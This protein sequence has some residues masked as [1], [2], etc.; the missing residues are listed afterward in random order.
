MRRLTLLIVLLVGSA[1]A[2]A[3]GAG[4]EGAEPNRKGLDFFE[5]KIRPMLVTHC[6][7]CH[8]AGAVGKKNLKGGLLLDSRDASRTGGES[9]SAVV[10]GKPD[11]SLLISALKQ[12]SFKMPPKGKL[13]DELIAHFV[14]WIEMGAPDP[15]DGVT[16]AASSEIDLE[17]GRKHWA[18]QPLA[19]PP[20]P[21]VKD[22]GWARTP[23]DQFVRARQEAAEVTPNA[24]ADA[25]TLIR[26]AYFD[27]IGL[28]PQPED[29]ES[30]VSEVEKDP[31][32]AYGRLIDE[33]LNSE[34]YGERWARHWLDVT[35]FAESNGYAFDGD[36]PN[37]WHYRDFVIRALNSDMPYDQFVRLQIAGDLLTNLDVQ[38][39]D[40]AQAAVNTIAATGLL[41]AGTYTTQQTQ[42]ER[43]RSRYEQLDDIVST[44]GTS[45]LGLTV[46]CSRCHS[47]KF[48]PLSQFDYYRMA[49][50]FAEVGF[51]DTGINMQPEAF[52][53]AKNAYDAA[54]APLAAAR[55]KFEQEQFSGRFDQWI[56]SRTEESATSPASAKLEA[57]HHVGP[58]A[59]GNFDAAF[60]QVFPPEL[61]TELSQS[62]EDGKLKWTEQ[63]EWKDGEAHNDK[64]TGTNGA[65]YLF[66]VV[67]G[68]QP[69]VMSLSLG[70]DDGIKLWVNGREVLSKKVGRDVAA[71]D[72][73]TVVIQLAAGRNELLMK[74]VN[75]GGAT[76]F[77]F[78]A[79]AAATPADVT[80]ILA[81]PV[82]KRD[83]PQKQKLVDWYKGYDLDWL[84]LNQLVARQETQNP[85][86]DLT[87]V[88]AARVRGTTY[89]F[90]DDTFK[91]YHLRR[92]NAD[93]KEDEAAPGFLQVLMRTDQ[94]EMQW[95]A[96][97]EA[98]DKTRPGRIG[99]ADWLTD[100]DRGGGHLL[101]RVI[102]NR[103]WHHHFGRGIVATPSDFGTRGE[104]PSH[105]DL[106]D[107]L[108]SEL[109][110]G[111]WK[112]KPIHKLIMTS[113]V[114][115]QAGDVT[116]SGR[117]HDPENLLLWRR[118]SRRLEAEIIRDSLL[119]VSGTLD[120]TM[121]GKGT[122]DQSSTRRSM[123]FTVK[124]SE[125]IP[126][127]QLFDAPDTMQAIATREESTVAPQALAL[128]NSPIIRDLATKFA[129][130][131][132]PNAET[133]I[134]QAI[135][136]AYQ[137]A[138]SRPAT[139]AE[140]AA[141]TEFIQRQKE[142]R[143][144]DADAES[145]AVR[146]FCHLIL[147]M[148][149]FVYID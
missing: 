130:Q 141:M 117:Q 10:P 42:K 91:V 32:G 142:S 25:S 65:N 13:P 66:R 5:A 47:H 133:S 111:G 93:N 23:V 76:G 18:F 34:H 39:T 1:V 8:S 80:A 15:R 57:W 14:K 86:P 103:L 12:E 128:L 131:V 50:C 35:R 41:V 54:L 85:K 105:P 96:D 81:L 73:E 7:E 6:Y 139:D 122:L 140:R 11:E 48:D 78:A 121:F 63:P 71:A 123:Y 16:V 90:G 56:A 113:A 125:L 46:G 88:F 74:I 89:Q 29:V 102:V 60:D 112:L 38:T 146:D 45:L 119:A 94:L 134:E 79:S 118:N 51:A 136:R 83:E 98:A 126:I 132:R 68:E 124:R 87:N 21:E 145:L 95:L 22:S 143:A 43:E 149:E 101:A 59:A 61:D 62:F 147:C 53:D 49:S 72:Q 84:R 110:R 28:P 135:D 148:N 27:L 97:P 58:F 4:V 109:I 92:G 108:A 138:L 129:V 120:R 55:T 127:L 77:Y 115:M 20:P 3:E 24:I 137:V 104:K 82:D 64:L 9:G 44:L 116:E 26:R 106:L 17:A 67:E 37:A 75:S 36:R 100:V 70:S 107:W 114:Y 40:E 69:Q 52:R 31:D 33:L 99:L 19:Q 144:A 2:V 30:F